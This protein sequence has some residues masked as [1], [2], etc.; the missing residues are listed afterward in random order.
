MR[1]VS[2]NWGTKEWFEDKFVDA[3]TRGDRWYIHLRASQSFR[4]KLC[5]DLIKEYLASPEVLRILDIGCGLGLFMD[6]LFE[7][8]PN[9]LM[10]GCDI[11]KNAIS[12]NQKRFPGF[13]FKV[14][15]LPLLHYESEKFDIICALEVIYY[16]SDEDQ[17]A[18]LEEIRRCLKK[19]GHFLLS[20]GINRDE[21]YFEERNIM[22]L[23]SEYFDIIDIVYNN[24][25]IY[26]YLER[27]FLGI[28]I[29]AGIYENGS[30]SQIDN[31][32]ENRG[33]S[34]I[35][36]NRTFS[37]LASAPLQLLKPPA[38]YLLSNTKLVSVCNYISKRV[39]KQRGRTH[40]IILARKRCS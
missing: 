14:T 37:A 33:I 21:R 27:L 8:N 15:S 31:Y 34:S 3:H 16:L 2:N 30:L 22:E 12:F 25:R 40:L 35:L 1:D 17:R 32:I 19:G 18:S 5:H 24:A 9:N 11:S 13:Q 10:Y 39:L 28:I 6:R 38:R 4:M 29:I 36:K 7:A 20:G 23:I 26:R